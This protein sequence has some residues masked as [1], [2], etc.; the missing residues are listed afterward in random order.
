MPP[1]FVSVPHL[2]QGLLNAGG[3][4]PPRYFFIRGHQ[5]VL[6]TVVCLTVGTRVYVLR[7]RLHVWGSTWWLVRL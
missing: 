3:M 6:P 5:C 1:V 2:T 4:T 7:L